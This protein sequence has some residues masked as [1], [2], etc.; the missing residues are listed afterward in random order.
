MTFPPCFRTFCPYKFCHITVYILCLFRRFLYIRFVTLYVL[1]LY[2]LSFIRGLYRFRRYRYKFWHYTYCHW[3][4]KPCNWIVHIYANTL[5]LH[6]MGWNRKWNLITLFYVNKRMNMITWSWYH[7][8][9]KI[10]IHPSSKDRHPVLCIRI[11][12]RPDQKLFAS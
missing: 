1:S 2:V 5:K 10:T 4:M 7:H 12:I 6:D 11:R 8:D 9:I 3:I